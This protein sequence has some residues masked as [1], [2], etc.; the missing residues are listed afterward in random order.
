MSRV[1]QHGIVAFG[2]ASCSM[3]SQ[4]IRSSVSLGFGDD[5]AF[6]FVASS[7]IQVTTDQIA[8][9]ILGCRAKNVESSAL[10]QAYHWSTV[11]SLSED[12]DALPS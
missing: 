5:A 10:T 8:S 9:N 11:D 3:R 2:P 12:F 7:L 1:S 4:I 6:R